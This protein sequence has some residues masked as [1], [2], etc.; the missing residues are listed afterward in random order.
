MPSNDRFLSD[1]EER[2]R[3]RG[4]SAWEMASHAEGAQAIYEARVER[5]PL[6]AMTAVFELQRSG[7]PLTHLA[8]S[9]ATLSPPP[10]GITAQVVRSIRFEDLRS[11]ARLMAGLPPNVGLRLTEEELGAV[12]RPG[13][14]GQE[15]RFYARWAARYVRALAHGPNPTRQLADAYHYGENTIRGFV[16]QARRRGLLTNAPAGKAGGEL[17]TKAEWLVASD[18]ISIENDPDGE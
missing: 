8:F 13:R 6:W 3:L 14:R 1:F 9:P 16:R 18:E 7:T 5:H 11:E 15:D 10:E 4:D 12:R 2:E 17:T